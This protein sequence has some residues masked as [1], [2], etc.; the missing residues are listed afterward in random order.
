MKHGKKCPVCG[1]YM[2]E[3]HQGYH[4]EMCG[5]IE[6]GCWLENTLPTIIY[7]ISLLF[8]IFLTFKDVEAKSVDDISTLTE[9]IYFEARNQPLLGQIGVGCV[10]L[11]RVKS[12]HYPNNVYDVVWQHKQFSYT[13]DGKS[14][15]MY[16]RDAW[17]MAR[18]MS[19]HVLNTDACD[20]FDGMDHY[21]NKSISS[22]TWYEDMKHIMSVGDHSFYRRDES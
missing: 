13:H 1:F 4:C 22:A 19:Q 18:S 7:I 9:A 6:T 2:E 11:N 5:N 3:V 17:Y 20:I 14:E 16:D 21:L 15:R 12:K 8:L 10:I